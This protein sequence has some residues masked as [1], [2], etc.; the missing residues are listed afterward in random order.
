MVS[1]CAIDDEG[2]VGWYLYKRE[3]NESGSKSSRIRRIKDP[4]IFP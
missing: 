1:V 2:G 3:G 4:T